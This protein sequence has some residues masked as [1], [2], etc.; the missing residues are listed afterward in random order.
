MPFKPASE[1]KTEILKVANEAEY[2]P[3][4]ENTPNSISQKTT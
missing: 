4:S 1:I 3:I 2:P